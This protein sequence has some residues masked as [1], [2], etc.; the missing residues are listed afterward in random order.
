[1]SAVMPLMPGA[2]GCG[3]WGKD[4]AEAGEGRVQALVL[5]QYSVSPTNAET[6]WST[7]GGILLCLKHASMNN[8]N[9][10]ERECVYNEIIKLNFNVGE[11]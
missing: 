11:M 4:H 6:Y 9:K 8:E 7:N 1:M 5:C 10:R 3:G 2:G